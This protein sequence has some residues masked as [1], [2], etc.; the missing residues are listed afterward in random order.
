MESKNLLTYNAKVVQ[1][2]QSFYAPVSIIYGYEL[3][4][5]TTYCFLSRILPYGFNDTDI[6][7]PKQ[8]Q[9][10]IKNIFKNIFVAKK[11]NTADICP[12]IPRVDWS[13]NTVYDCYSDDK[14]MFA[15]TESGNNV[16]NFYVRN[17]FDQVFKCLSNNTKLI[18]NIPTGQTSTIEPYF[19]PG[20]Y[21]TNNIFKGEDDYKWKYIYTIDT[22]KKIKFMDT[23][24]MPIPIGT[25]RLNPLVSPVGHGGIEVIN[26]IYGG[27]GY[28]R[29]INSNESVVIEGDGTGAAATIVFKGNTIK[30]ILITNPGT[31]YTYA[32]VSIDTV[33]T[34][35]PSEIAILDFPISPIGGHGFDPISELGTNNIMYTVEFNGDEDGK[36]PTNI[37]YRQI[38]L[39]VNPISLNSLDL[40]SDDIYKTSTDLLVAAGAGIYTPDE[41]IYQGPKNNPT[42]EGSMLSFNTSTNII[43]ILPIKGTLRDDTS[44]FGNNSGCVRTLLSSTPP[45]FVIESGYLTYIENRPTIT[46]SIDGIEQFKFVLSY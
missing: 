40:A 45:D 44:I 23:N 37:D 16:Y 9:K 10:Y 6:E 46:R 7:E 39:I 11:I 28:H 3:P 8:T 33:D 26:V 42:F 2:E 36:V 22:G 12:V 1:I 18:T 25:N 38:G 32:T 21:Q 19:Q 31:N 20:T 24:W 5:N 43:N 41:L 34:Y 17:K 35:P 14:D 13:E 4:I 29:D 15:K 27:A 30:D